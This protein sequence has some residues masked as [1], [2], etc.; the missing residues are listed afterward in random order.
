M[1]FVSN[2]YMGKEM[3]IKIGKHLM[4]N[5][6][7]INMKQNIKTRAIEGSIRSFVRGVI[8]GTLKVP[9]KAVIFHLTER[10]MLETIARKRIAEIKKGSVTGKTEE[11][12]NKYLNDRGVKTE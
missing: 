8:D 12:L 2:R 6:N 3:F 4:F 11:E 5:V 10:D 9:N 7:E 1:K